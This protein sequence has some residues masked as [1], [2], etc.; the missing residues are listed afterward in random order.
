MLTLV[1]V[2]EEGWGERGLDQTA[3]LT[4]IQKRSDR[5][6]S[7]TTSSKCLEQRKQRKAFSRRGK[8]CIVVAVCCRVV[9]FFLNSQTQSHIYNA[10][11]GHGAG[12]F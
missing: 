3:K 1:S 10:A 4:Q 6:D 9:D 5:R 11:T 2:S 8:M 7:T 12:P